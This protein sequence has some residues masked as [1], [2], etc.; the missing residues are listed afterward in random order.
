MKSEY[1]AR[2]VIFLVS[3]KIISVFQAQYINHRLK[4]IIYIIN[5]L[6][7]SSITILE[8]NFSLIISTY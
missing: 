7:S 2:I 6:I 1:L 4:K 3:N 5:F 8:K